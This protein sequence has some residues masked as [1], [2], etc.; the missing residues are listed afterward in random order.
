MIGAFRRVTVGSPMG[1][2]A[3]S[4]GSRGFPQHPMGIYAQNAAV[5]HENPPWEPIRS[6]AMPWDA[7]ARSREIPSRVSFYRGMFGHGEMVNS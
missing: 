5:F 3:Y 2:R 7:P 6:R 1:F 4:A